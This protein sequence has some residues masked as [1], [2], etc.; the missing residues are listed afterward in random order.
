MKL[1]KKKT[2]KKEIEVK[3]AT[4]NASNEKAATGLLGRRRKKK[5]MEMV[6]VFSLRFSLCVSPSSPTTLKIVS[7]H[8]RQFETLDGAMS[9]ALCL[10][11]LPLPPL[12]FPLLR[13]FSFS[14]IIVLGAMA[15]IAASASQQMPLPRRRDD[16]KAL[17]LCWLCSPHLYFIFTPSLLHL[18]F[19]FKL[20]S[21]S[22]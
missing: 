11:C 21:P 16:D 13:F 7:N 5:A 1:E 10:N 19:I 20:S 9:G 15:M 12:T 18:Y 14:V 6:F 17:L 22:S 4:T 2:A 8:V 3:M